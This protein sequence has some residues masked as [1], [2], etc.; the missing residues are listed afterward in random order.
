M[1]GEE[2]NDV[3]VTVFDDNAPEA[4]LAGKTLLYIEKSQILQSF[5]LYINLFNLFN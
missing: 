5:P 1:A 4:D 2:L 3:G